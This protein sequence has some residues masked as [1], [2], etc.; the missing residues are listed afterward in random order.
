MKLS[1]IEIRHVKNTAMTLTPISRA[2]I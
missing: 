1:I 2:R